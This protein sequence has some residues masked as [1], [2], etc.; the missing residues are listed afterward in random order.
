MYYMC[1][2]RG[3][4]LRQHFENPTIELLSSHGST[5]LLSE[6]SLQIAALKEQVSSLKGKLHSHLE[7]SESTFAS[8]PMPSVERVS[9][10]YFMF[11]LRHRMTLMMQPV[12][13]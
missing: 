4:Q 12:A 13:N 11:G 10:Q 3:Q 9:C 5:N 6:K 2:L 7:A 1:N 8:F